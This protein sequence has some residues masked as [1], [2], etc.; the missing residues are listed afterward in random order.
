MTNAQYGKLVAGLIAAWF[1][2]T[3]TAS[4]LHVFR[5]DFSRPAILFALAGLTPIVVFAVWSAASKGFRHFTESLDPS[6]LTLVQSWRIVG[7]AF[8][9]L[10]AYAILPRVFAL[11]A[12]WGD[13]FI[14]ATAPFVALRLANPEHRRGFILWQG[15][16]ILDLVLAVT[17]AA[18]AMLIDPH[19]VAPT[20]LTVL[21]LSLI[22]TF[23]VPLLFILHIISIGQARRWPALAHSRVGEQLPSRA[24]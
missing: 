15:L 5:S 23:G 18:T 20:P 3:L 14:G 2:F 24:V 12:G 19:G 8:L 7:Y 6:I 22:P 11:S 21:P 4:A 13:I 10:Y 16:G 1:V 17:F 9:V